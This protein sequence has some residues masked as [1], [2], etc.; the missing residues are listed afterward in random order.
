MKAI[1]PDVSFYQSDPQT[2]SW[3]DFVKMR[4][5]G[6]LYVII[7]AG[8][9]LWTDRDFK[10]N[11][12]A[13][14]AAGLPRGCYWFYDS[15]IEPK[16]QAEL[17]VKALDG[18][19][20]E[21]PM[22]ADFE[23]NYGGA[24]GKWQ[25]FYNFLEAVKALAPG[26]EIGVYTAYYYWLER[27]VSVGI[28]AAS[29]EYFKQYPLWVANYGTL[30][31]LVPKPWNTWTFWQ[32]TDNGDGKMYGVA[33][34][35]IDL[36]Y[37]NGSDSEFYE[38]FGLDGESPL[39]EPEEEND[40]PTVNMIG[41]LVSNS[42]SRRALRSAAKVEGNPIGYA[43]PASH[44]MQ[45]ADKLVI[46]KDGDGGVGSKAGDEWYFVVN[47]DVQFYNTNNFG[48][49]SGW[50]AARHKGEV[51][52]SFTPKAGE[53]PQPEPGDPAPD[54]AITADTKLKTVTI[55]SDV[56]MAVYFNGEKVR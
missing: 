50:V 45:A 37:Y 17:W 39:P 22:F 48:K 21:L 27:T 29:L 49:S 13:A 53:S 20:G 15:R 47:A 30:N 9:N 40:M 54:V 46:A 51:L 52:C 19:L 18:D 36:N 5:A 2:E 10:R 12:M 8:Q 28:P 1:G 11:W 56:D 42:T 55:N 24:Y 7:R 14:K 33:S 43:N 3:I 23:D 16:R 6:A 26:K 4:A 34:E 44:V 41:T 25:D 38:R 31:P 32:Y 35:E